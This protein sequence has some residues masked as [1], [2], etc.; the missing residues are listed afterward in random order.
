M[1]VISHDIWV[2][3]CELMS[4]S[5]P[6]VQL[7][8]CCFEI[9]PWSPG[10]KQNFHHS[11]LPLVTG[12]ILGAE[13]LS[14]WLSSTSLTSSFPRFHSYEQQHQISIILRGRWIAQITYIW[15]WKVMEAR[16]HSNTHSYK[17]ARLTHSALC[18]WLWFSPGSDLLTLTQNPAMGRAQ[19]EQ[20][21][22][23]HLTGAFSVCASALP[24]GKSRRDW[25]SR[26]ADE[27]RKA[28]R[29]PLLEDH[30]VA[31]RW[32]PNQRLTGIK[33]ILFSYTKS[34]GNCPGDN[35]DD[36]LMENTDSALIDGLISKLL[37]LL[38]RPFW[39]RGWADCYRK[40]CPSLLIANLFYSS[41]LV[42]RGASYTQCPS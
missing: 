31:W 16:L 9:L 41:S 20:R 29:V 37:N 8:T 13:A 36:A 35:R 15:I 5:H 28:P 12:D 39:R 10:W 22:S 7:Y 4:K 25:L 32:N 42:P 3:R 14:E 27:E 6:A 18:P 24:T 33:P 23:Q 1:G 34:K 11:W 21:G 40:A 17:Y 26:S 2:H 19:E 38:T 30:A